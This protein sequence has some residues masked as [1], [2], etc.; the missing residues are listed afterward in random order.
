MSRRRDM[1][2]IQPGRYWCLVKWS[3]APV[4]G[5][6]SFPSSL[7]EKKNTVGTETDNWNRRQLRQASLV[8]YTAHFHR[9]GIILSMTVSNLQRVLS[10]DRLHANHFL[11]SPVCASTSCL[12]FWQQSFKCIPASGPLYDNNHNGPRLLR[13]TYWDV[14]T[15]YIWQYFFPQEFPHYNKVEYQHTL[16][17]NK[18]LCI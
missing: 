18:R 7:L 5:Q 13:Q 10:F 8:Q 15:S 6:K 1:A 17:F 2:G 11:W 16:I 12:V 4:G 3:S 14:A 9:T